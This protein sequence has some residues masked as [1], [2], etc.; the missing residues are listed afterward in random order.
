[1]VAGAGPVRR[2]LAAVVGCVAETVVAFAAAHPNAPTTT[3][4]AQLREVIT[5]G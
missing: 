2:I 5:S 4:R 1:M 3:T